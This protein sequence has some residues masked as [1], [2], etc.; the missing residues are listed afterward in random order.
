M[1]VMTACHGRLSVCYTRR[2]IN[3]SQRHPDAPR[4]TPED[5]EALDLFDSLA[6]DAT[7]R[8]DMVLEPGDMQFLH[9]HPILHDRTAFEDWPEP[10]RKRHLLRLWLAPWDARPL[11]PSF[12]GRFGSAEVGNRGGIVVPDA[13]LHAPL[14]AV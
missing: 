10:E 1:P 12:A 7:L 5:I 2:N 14:E 8:L 3:S 9:N 4:L 6:N 13:K 11:D